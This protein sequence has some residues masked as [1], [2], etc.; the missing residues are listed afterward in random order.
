MLSNPEDMWAGYL[1][2][3]VFGK[4]MTY[5]KEVFYEEDALHRAGLPAG[6]LLYLRREGYEALSPRPIAP[7]AVTPNPYMASSENSVHNDSYSSDVTNAVLPLGIHSSLALSLETQN[8]QAPSAAFYDELG[9][10]ITPFVGGVAITD[11]TGDTIVRRGMFVPSK[12]DTA[13]SYRVQI[14]YSFVD[15]D[16]NIVLPTTHGHIIVLR[17]MDESGEILPIF[18]KILDINV[19]DYAKQLLSEEIDTRLLSIIYDYSGNL[20]FVT[21]GFR[22][23]PARDPAGF[24]GYISREYIEAGLHGESLPREEHIFFHPLELGEGAENGIA[25]FEHGAVI[26]TSRAC[27]MLNAENGVRIDWVTPYESNGANDAGPGSAYTGGGLAYG[28]GSTPT[29][30]QELVLFTDNLDP[31]NLL[32]LSAQTGEIVAQI[33]VLDQLPDDIPV[34]VE[35]S[36]LVYCDGG[37]RTSALVCNWFGA[38]NAGLADPDADSSIQSYANLYDANW[39]QFG[40][41]YIAPGV[42]RVDIVK[43]ADGYTAEKVWFRGDISDTSMIKLST[44]TGYLY[45]YWQNMDS[46]MWCYEVLDFDSSETVYEM[47]VST[48]PAYNN[49]AV[50]MIADVKGNSLDCP[51]NSMEIVRWQDDFVYLPDSPVKALDADSME[52]YRISDED[53]RSLSSSALAP[54]SYLMKVAADNL[55][56]ENRFAF[57]ITDLDRAAEDYALFYADADG[58]LHEFSGEW[59]LCTEDRELLEGSAVPPASEVIELQLAVADGDPADLAQA[60]KA[61]LL[62]LILAA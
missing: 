11:N 14:S 13:E 19:V 15:K 41:Q 18:E 36:I 9:N 10:T 37:D 56:G 21:G 12:H 40:N 47:P 25:S 26:L 4:L 34:A 46:D 44:A 60:E 23:D 6:A 33:P 55:S 59:R 22:I 58:M 54:A 1:L 35:N 61:L 7:N 43:T 31:V 52:R 45:G 39:M 28:G 16:N 32:A 50:G 51:T 38:G 57:R 30:T 27:Y 42:E 20:W 5:F 48:S 24:L 53:F 8:P 49:L 29:L 17:T 3:R 62:A 2:P